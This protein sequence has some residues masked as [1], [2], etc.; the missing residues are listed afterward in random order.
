MNYKKR[1]KS[2]NLSN[3]F[4]KL[5]STLKI[6][7]PN[8]NIASKIIILWNIILIVS[9]FLPWLYKNTENIFWNS[10]HPIWWNIGFFSIL[11][12]IILIIISLFSLEFEKV[13]L[14]FNIS[15]KEYN[16]TILIWLFIIIVWAI[17]VSFIN[18]LTVFLNDISVWKWV[19]LYILSWVVVFA[20]WLIKKVI[21]KNNNYESFINE[22]KNNKT[23]KNNKSNMKL[24][25]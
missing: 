22:T 17:Y 4:I 15:Y 3:F 16:I 19:I 14:S 20:W 5:N 23:E 9:L 7:I 11:F 18:G 13:K 21:S 1:K 8:L 2:R 25:F 10:F 24:P 12:S 6:N